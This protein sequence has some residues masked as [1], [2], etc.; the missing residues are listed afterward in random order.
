M[1]ETNIVLYYCH[2]FPQSVSTVYRRWSKPLRQAVRHCWGL[3]LAHACLHTAGLLMP[4]GTPWDVQ[5]RTPQR[6]TTCQSPEHSKGAWCTPW[7]HRSKSP[8]ILTKSYLKEKKRVIISISLKGDK[9]FDG[10][11][12]KIYE[13]RDEYV[14]KSTKLEINW[15]GNLNKLLTMVFHSNKTT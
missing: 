6:W 1:V 11:C 2:F 3:H 9:A 12:M 8:Y 7:A 10:S 14:W 15:V 5:W 13:F 4:S